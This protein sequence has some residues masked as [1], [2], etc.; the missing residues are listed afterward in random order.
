MRPLILLALAAAAG[1]AQGRPCTDND[2]TPYQLAGIQDGWK[3]A[4]ITGFLLC[5][6]TLSAETEDRLGRKTQTGTWATANKSIVVNFL[7]GRAIGKQGY[8]LEWQLPYS[9]VPPPASYESG[10]R[11]LNVPVLQVRGANN[12][13]GSSGGGA[14]VGIPGGATSG[15]TGSTENPFKSETPSPGQYYDARFYFSPDGAWRFLTASTDGNY[16]LNQTRGQPV[17][18]Y[19]LGRANPTVFDTGIN[20]ITVPD[21]VIDG[22]WYGGLMVNVKSDGIWSVYR[23]GRAQSELFQTGNIAGYQGISSKTIFTVTSGGISHAWRGGSD[24]KIPSSDESRPIITPAVAAK[25][26]T[27]TP[28]Q[29]GYVPETPAQPAVYG[30]ATITTNPVVSIYRIEADYLIAVTGSRDSCQVQLLY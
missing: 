27:G 18:K 21:L 11:L 25:P 16:P 24:C 26:A 10:S 17:A 1:V 29:V 28:G 5:D 14:A 23:V 20:L 4:E 15:G 30:P 13:S 7:N 9:Q 12:S 2:L 6:G 22:R 8:N 19:D 3:A